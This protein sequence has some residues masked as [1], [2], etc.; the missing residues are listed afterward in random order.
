[1]PQNLDQYNSDSLLNKESEIAQKVRDTEKQMTVSVNMDYENLYSDMRL[2]LRKMPKNQVTESVFQLLNHNGL[3]VGYHQ[4]RTEVPIYSKVMITR[5]NEL[6]GV[7]LS[8]QDLGIDDRTGETDSVDDCIYASYFALIRAGLLCYEKEFKADYDLH[9]L[10]ITYIY[11]LIL[12]SLSRA[13]SFTKFKLDGIQLACAYLYFRHY[14]EFN[15]SSALSRT[16]RLFADVID[17]E[18]IDNYRPSFETVSRYKSLKDIGKVL[19]DLNI[20]S[21]NPNQLLLSIV[22]N[23]G[24]NFFYYIMGSID[25]LIATIVT[26]KY[27]TSLFNN[28]KIVNNNLQSSIEKITVQKYLNKIKFS[29]IKI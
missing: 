18:T 12:K 20:L 13:N 26:T 16:T 21:T 6:A 8:I 29:V 27:P 17:K 19:V 11:N 25:F 3:F 1:M 9:K 5:S 23:S 28:A 10:A 4:K 14:L 2:F 22:Q 15:H 24:K 7:I